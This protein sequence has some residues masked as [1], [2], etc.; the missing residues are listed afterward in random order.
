MPKVE[1]LRKIS[2]ED[3][4]KDSALEEVTKRLLLPEFPLD[5][6]GEFL[7]EATGSIR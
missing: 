5:I 6:P 1:Y 7:V 4:Q 3:V 2:P